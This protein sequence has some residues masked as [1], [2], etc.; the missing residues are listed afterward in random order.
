[1]RFGSQMLYSGPVTVRRGSADCEQ[2]SACVE[3]QAPGRLLNLGD[4]RYAMSE[5]S[6]GTLFQS[7]QTTIHRQ[8]QIWLGN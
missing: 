4:F 3:E 6:S 2:S 7:P 8:S 5:I 1:M